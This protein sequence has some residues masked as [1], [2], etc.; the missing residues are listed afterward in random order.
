LP[1]N[2]GQ[3]TGAPKGCLS[4]KTNF[5]PGW[6]IKKQRFSNPKMQFQNQ[7]LRNANTYP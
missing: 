2:A 6:L 7:K 1:R 3:A 4:R 5:S